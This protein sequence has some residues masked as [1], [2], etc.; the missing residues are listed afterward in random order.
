[1]H[2]SEWGK[3]PVCPPGPW[4]VDSPVMADVTQILNAIAAA[5][6]ERREQVE[7]GRVSHVGPPFFAANAIVI[8][9]GALRKRSVRP[10]D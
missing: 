1:M 9:T 8:Q 2:S 5:W 7:S 10:A 4:R 3:V 6:K